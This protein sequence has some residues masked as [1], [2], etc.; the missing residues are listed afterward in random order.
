YFGD[1][2][3]F[4]VNITYVRE[5]EPLGTAGAIGLALPWLQ[6]DFIVTNA[7]LLTRVSFGEL[8]AFHGVEKNDL[9]I[10]I[11]ESTYQLRY[12]V[13]ETEGSRVIGIREKPELHHF[14]NGGIYVMHPR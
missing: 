13:V 10:G 11:I 7:D 9:T 6:R 2:R 3:R 14:V 5:T 4:G 8:V 12:G 1:G